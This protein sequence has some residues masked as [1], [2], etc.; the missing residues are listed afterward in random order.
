VEEF[1]ASNHVTGSPVEQGKGDGG[2]SPPTR[3]A[4]VVIPTYNE[5][6]NLRAIVTAALAEQEHIAGFDLHVLVADSHSSDGTLDIAQRMTEENP[7]V[8][9]LDVI[10]R[11][12]GVGLYRGLRHAV[13]VLGADVLLEMDADFQHNPQD[14]RKFLLK[15]AEGYDLVV[16][17]RF[18]PGSMNRMPFYRRVLSVGANQV[19]RILLGLKGVTE[20]TTSYRAFTRETF[21]RVKPESVPWEERSFIPV[22]VFLVRML[23]S[24]AS[25]TE[26]PITMHPRT[27]GHSKMAYWP[28][29]R[30]IFLFAIRSR[31]GRKTR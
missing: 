25:A 4:V 8:H 21:L 22:P 30:D 11:G 18:I 23:E 17:S 6:E 14:I 26:V 10:E 28:Y 24:G 3:C 12:I 20:I 15:I 5:S 2:S 1:L 13:E 27:R 29:I 19:I 16:G 9:L 31:L 7:S